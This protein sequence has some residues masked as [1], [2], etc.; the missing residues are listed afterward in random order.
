MKKKSAKQ[1]NNLPRDAAHSNKNCQMTAQQRGRNIQLILLFLLIHN[2]VYLTPKIL[3][4]FT[5]LQ[6]YRILHF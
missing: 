2:E 1:S 6:F 4:L 5:L 3:T